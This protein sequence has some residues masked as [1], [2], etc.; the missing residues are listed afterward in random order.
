MTKFHDPC[1]FKKLYMECC[2]R[3]GEGGQKVVKNCPRGLW[4]APKNAVPKVGL[5]IIAK[6]IFFGIIIGKIA[7]YISLTTVCEK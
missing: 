1:I 6:I 7:Q 2:P 3:W 4:M 5:I